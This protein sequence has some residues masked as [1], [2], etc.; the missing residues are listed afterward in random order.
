MDIQIVFRTALESRTYK[1]G[2]MSENS[3]GE[4]RTMWNAAIYSLVSFEHWYTGVCMWN[5]Y[6]IAPNPI[7]QPNSFPCQSIFQIKIS[8]LTVQHLKAF[9]SEIKKHDK[10]KGYIIQG[11]QNNSGWARMEPWRWWTGWW[12]TQRAIYLEEGKYRIVITGESSDQ[13]Q[14]KARL[15]H[16]L[17]GMEN[18][19]C[20]MWKWR[21]VDTVSEE[22]RHLT[23]SG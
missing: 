15:Q 5:K 16:W 1:I 19:A 22:W 13:G 14:A 6:F 8:K 11:V 10:R 23:S 9:I 4:V 17:P 18:R 7:V 2:A 20:Y 21:N 3:K 12:G